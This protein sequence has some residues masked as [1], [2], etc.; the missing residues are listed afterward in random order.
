M[1]NRKVRSCVH[2]SRDLSLV[3]GPCSGLCPQVLFLGDSTNRGMMYFLVEQVNSSLED[4]GKV[5]HTL[6]YRNLNGGRTT[7]SYSYYPQF[8]VEKVQR[9]TFKQALLQLLSR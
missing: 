2:G 9:P 8:W 1:A 7:V 3:S 6:L 4:W 5:H